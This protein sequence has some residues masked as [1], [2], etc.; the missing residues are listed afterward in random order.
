MQRKSCLNIKVTKKIRKKERLVQQRN[1]NPAQVTQKCS[2]LVKLVIHKALKRTHYK[3]NCLIQVVTK[4]TAHLFL[5]TIYRPTK[6]FL[7]Q[8]IQLTFIDKI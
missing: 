8:C 5:I 7:L 6:Q 2:T 4:N 1:D 3:K